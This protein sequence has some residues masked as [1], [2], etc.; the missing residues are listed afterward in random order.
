MDFNKYLQTA[1]ALA[2]PP[3]KLETVKP[4][5]TGYVWNQE[6]GKYEPAVSGG[7]AKLET[8]KPGEIGLNW[9][10]ATGK[11]EQA[12]TGGPPAPEHDKEAEF[13][14]GLYANDPVAQRKAL[15]A[16]AAKRVSHPQ[17]SQVNV[18]LDKTYGGVVAKGLADADVA[19]IDAA[20]SAPDRLRSA[21]EVQRI[22]TQTP[23]TGS[24][25][26]MRLAITKAL[27][28]AGLIDGKTV[29]STEDLASVLANQTLDAIKTSGLGS[30]QGF[31]DKDRQF[32]QDAKSGRL[33]TNAGTLQYIA[34]LNERAA[35][36]SMERGNSVI[37][38]LKKDP[39]FSGSTAG[40]LEEVTMPTDSGVTLPPQSAIEA[41]MRRRGLK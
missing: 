35:I 10:P 30:G 3:A 31:T 38:R 6:K 36:A 8:L 26:E 27:S 16:L 21:R 19:A 40:A 5:E 33:E 28:T 13:L 41:E 23:I 1:Q 25:A 4:G 9:N 12:A 39:N 17:P 22:L 2:K 20:R 32:L 7:P 29:T 24:G 15:E 37:R 11:W 14:K 18:T 34:R